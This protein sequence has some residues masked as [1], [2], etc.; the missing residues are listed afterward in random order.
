M[1]WSR[2]DKRLP[3]TIYGCG[4][5]L[6]RD[7][8]HILIFGGHRWSDHYR[9]RDEIFI[10]DTADLS[11]RESHI[12]CPVENQYYA[13]LVDDYNMNQIIL[14]GWIRQYFELWEDDTKGKLRKP[15]NDVISVIQSFFLNETIHIYTTN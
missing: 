1:K 6:T 2:T 9:D 11:I 3:D 15:S 14:C 7:E 5:V 8:K 4:C 10:I 12:K 13:V